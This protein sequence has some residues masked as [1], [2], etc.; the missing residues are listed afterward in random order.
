MKRRI[1]NNMEIKEGEREK[2][3]KKKQTRKEKDIIDILELR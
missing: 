2:K 1:N 3:R